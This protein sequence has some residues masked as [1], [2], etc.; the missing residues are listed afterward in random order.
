M[1]EYKTTIGQIQHLKEDKKIIVDDCNKDIFIER[2]YI[3]LIN[4][5]KMLYVSSINTEGKHIYN[6]ENNIKELMK[7]AKADDEFSCMLHKWI[8]YFERKLKSSLFYELSSLY[9]LNE[10]D[11]KK[12][13]YCIKYVGE[14][15][16]F[17]DSNYDYDKLPLFC[18]H[19]FDINTKSGY[20]HKDF[21][22]DDDSFKQKISVLKHIYDVGTGS[23]IYSED[24]DNKNS[25]II[26]HYI[27]DGE[28]VP[29]WVI[30]SCLTFGELQS[31]FNMSP[32]TIQQKVYYSFIPSK[33]PGNISN[34]E[35]L[36]FSGYLETIRNT[37]NVINHYEPILPFISINIGKK[38]TISKPSQFIKTLDILEKVYNKSLIKNINGQIIYEES[39]CNKIYRK[40]LEYMLYVM[41]DKK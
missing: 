35:L 7:I 14:I 21:V 38:A 32:K 13:I 29:L 20:Y 16:T 3:S 24:H 5:Y 30:P 8:G 37:R 22:E 23:N 41:K 28:I 33:E 31:I 36:K 19:F 34:K 12:D 26:K 4:P 15:K 27:E 10:D 39:E 40:S 9:A 2:N 11:K 6:S 25:K 1:K 17:I 18:E